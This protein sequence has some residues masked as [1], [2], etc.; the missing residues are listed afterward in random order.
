ME[1]S[2]I[3]SAVSPQEAE[4][5]NI[6]S[7]LENGKIQIQGVMKLYLSEQKENGPFMVYSYRVYK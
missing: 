4:M 1:N 5:V 6:S 2:K 7:E 3:V